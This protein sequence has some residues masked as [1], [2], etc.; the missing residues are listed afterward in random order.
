MPQPTCIILG[1]RNGWDK[2]SVYAKLQASGTRR[3]PSVSRGSSTDPRNVNTRYAGCQN[4]HVCLRHSVKWYAA[5]NEIEIAGNKRDLRHLREVIVT[6]LSKGKMALICLSQSHSVC[7]PYR[8]VT[9]T[10]STTCLMKMASRACSTKTGMH[11]L[12]GCPSLLIV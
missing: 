1:G 12:W 5:M 9:T 4:G 6:V 8:R 11:S 10:G 7:T 3:A 2:T